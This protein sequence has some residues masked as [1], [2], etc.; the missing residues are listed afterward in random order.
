MQFFSESRIRPNAFKASAEIQHKS[1]EFMSMKNLLIWLAVGHVLLKHSF[2]YADNL[3]IC[4]LDIK[5]PI[6]NLP[7]GIAGGRVPAV[8]LRCT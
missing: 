5:V 2:K 7:A 6:Y 4:N 8:L 1:N 3:F